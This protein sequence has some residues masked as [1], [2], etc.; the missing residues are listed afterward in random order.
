MEGR[1][2]SR[3][4]I[5]LFRVAAVAAL[6]LVASAGVSSSA[7]ADTIGLAFTDQGGIE[8]SAGIDVGSTPAKHGGGAAEQC[9]YTPLPMSA[10]DSVV[11]VDGSVIQGDGTGGWYEKVCANGTD[12]WGAVY[13]RPRQINPEELAAEA[14]RYL[15]LPAPVPVFS[16]ADEQIVNVPTWMAIDS[17]VW[18]PLQSTV[19][20]P[21][22]SVTVTAQPDE[23]DWDMGDGARL[24]C[25]AAR[26]PRACTHT[27]QWP[28]VGQ[29]D[30]A[31][32][33]TATVVWHASWTVTGAAGGGDLGTL[34]RTVTVPLRVGELQALNT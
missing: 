1:H 30:S 11:D 26:D 23:V 12:Y 28:S 25:R 15:A 4:R 31:Y 13:V 24:T 3:R 16:P 10:T 21:G 29:P 27:Y 20:V 18:Q 6:A 33:V 17:A 2:H 14:R 19:S 7:F 5:W 34:S 9:I 8:H 22:V 32:R